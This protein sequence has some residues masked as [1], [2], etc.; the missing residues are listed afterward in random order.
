MD[1]LKKIIDS[2]DPAT[3]ILR[4]VKIGKW[5][6]EQVREW[7]TTLLGKAKETSI[8]CVLDALSTQER[9][10]VEGSPLPLKETFHSKKRKYPD[11]VP[12]FFGSTTISNRKRRYAQ[13]SQES[14]S[15]LPAGA[16]STPVSS[17]ASES[18]T[19]GQKLIVLN[20]E[21]LIGDEGEKL[22]AEDAKLLK[23]ALKSRLAFEA[24]LDELHRLEDL[25]EW[26]LRTE[27]SSSRMELAAPPPSA[28][29]S[30][31]N[32]E[33]SKRERDILQDASS[34]NQVSPKLRCLLSCSR[35]LT[36]TRPTT[37]GRR[38]REFPN[39]KLRLL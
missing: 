12:S 11:N 2:K 29:V 31:E 37:S 8:N 36:L 16:A 18:L 10:D 35:R 22:T 6:L 4:D 30:I 5:S 13:D 32:S 24:A 28:P 26:R 27:K 7:L 20:F 38:L 21:S 17:L 33:S 23:D 1:G 14:K 3:L 25:Q 39:C 9:G 34:F 19:Y 15:G